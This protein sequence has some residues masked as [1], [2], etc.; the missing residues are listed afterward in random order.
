MT[1][2][3]ITDEI[4]ERQLQR[5]GPFG[6]LLVSAV[7]DD[8]RKERLRRAAIEQPPA[9][10]LSPPL[11]VWAR[12]EQIEF[13]PGAQPRFTIRLG[14]GGSEAIRREIAWAAS[15]G[16]EMGGLLWAHFARTLEAVP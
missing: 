2:V 8:L 4:V 14:Q 13:R 3:C 6:P 10:T 5:L 9:A 11:P 15:E 1:V 12:D 16:V 7:A